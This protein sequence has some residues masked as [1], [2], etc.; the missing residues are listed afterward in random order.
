MANVQKAMDFLVGGVMSK[1]TLDRLQLQMK[2]ASLS[3]NFERATVVRD[4]FQN[5]R[6]LARRLKQLE[7]AER[8]LNG[9]LPITGKR[10]QKLWLILR[11]GRLV[12]SAAAPRDKKRLVAAIEKLSSIRTQNLGLP[13]NLMEMN[14][15]MIVMSWFR[16]YPKYKQ[17]LISFEDAIEDCHQRI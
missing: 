17:Q 2:E 1:K 7:S 14:M 13:T 8:M 11:G 4:H 3:Q 12:G 16:K 6:W 9:I 15:Q 10:Y 5:L